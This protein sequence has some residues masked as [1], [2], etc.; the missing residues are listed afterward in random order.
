MAAGSLLVEEAGGRVSD[1]G[2]GP[3]RLR[4]Q[5]ILATNGRIHEALVALLSN[6]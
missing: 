2:G 5:E 1:F 3:L 4:S 6:S